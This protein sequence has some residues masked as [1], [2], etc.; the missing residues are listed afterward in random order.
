MYNLINVI[1]FFLCSTA[2]YSQHYDI[3][4]N[5]NY[6]GIHNIDSSKYRVIKTVF[7]VD[8]EKEIKRIFNNDGAL[9]EELVFVDGKLSSGIE[10]FIHPHFPFLEIPRSFQ[11]EDVTHRFS[12]YKNMNTTSSLVKYQMQYEGDVI[13][14]RVYNN[15]IQDFYIIDTDQGYKLY[16]K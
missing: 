10:Y 16:F 13:T 3:G 14:V 2:V 12:N 1:I 15:Q 9:M 5:T 7:N 4:H 11:I 8:P 6:F